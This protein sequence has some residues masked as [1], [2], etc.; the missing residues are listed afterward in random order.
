MQDV[1]GLR[2]NGTRAVNQ[3]HHI[4]HVGCCA[5]KIAKGIHALAGTAEGRQLPSVQR[6]REIRCVCLHCADQII[7][8]RQVEDAHAEIIIRVF[9]Q[10]GFHVRIRN[11]NAD[12]L[13]VK[14]WIFAQRIQPRIIPAERRLQFFA[15]DHEISVILHVRSRFVGCH[16]AGVEADEI[17]MKIGIGLCKVVQRVV[18]FVNCQ[19]IVIRCFVEADAAR[20]SAA[21]IPEDQHVAIGGVGGSRPSQVILQRVL[22]AH[23]LPCADFNVGKIVVRN[24]K[25]VDV[26]RT[27]AA[28]VPLARAA[29]LHD[30]CH[31]V[32]NVR[33]AHLVQ[34]V[35]TVTLQIR[36]AHVHQDSHR[37]G[38]R[39]RRR[40]SKQQ[41]TA[42]QQRKKLVFHWMVRLFS[43]FLAK[44]HYFYSTA[45]NSRCQPRFAQHKTL[46]T[47]VQERFVKA[48]PH[49]SAA[50]LAM[51]F[52]LSAHAIF[53]ICIQ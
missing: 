38:V 26:V 51:S 33:R 20:R 27:Q 32:R 7:H 9:A 3:R 35:H 19:P 39:A 14:G 29:C 10:A 11:R 31:V 53:S 41:Q 1:C 46:L 6:L 16:Q 45:A 21:V 2:R 40:K 25:A 5:V 37:G 4:H 42:K 34:V 49:S 50:R 12:A 24:R 47:R 28:V 8:C 18:D 13:R 23:A 36:A 17:Q 48:A 44:S 30:D 52:P 43:C 22:R 15:G